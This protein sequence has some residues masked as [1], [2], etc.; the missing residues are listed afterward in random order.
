M[1]KFQQ[2]L[3]ETVSILFLFFLS[4]Y[5]FPLTPLA[6]ND[7]VRKQQKQQQK[8]KENNST[9]ENTCIT[10]KSH[11]I[12]IL[13]LVSFPYLFLFA[14]TVF[15]SEFEIT[16]KRTRFFSFSVFSKVLILVAFFLLLLRFLDFGALKINFCLRLF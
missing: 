11:H 1:Q 9:N 12:N 6:R 7:A 15:K 10:A 5:I 14:S 8:R 2:F 13:T 4:I 3:H 16:I